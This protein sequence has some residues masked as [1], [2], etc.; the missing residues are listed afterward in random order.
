M[1]RQ[2][3]T[4]SL[5][6][7]LIFIGAHDWVGTLHLLPWKEGSYRERKRLNFA[8]FLVADSFITSEPRSCFFLNELLQ[9]FILTPLETEFDSSSL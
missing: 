9:F 1:G 5:A 6:I 8:C 4:P 2:D 7:L 3:Y